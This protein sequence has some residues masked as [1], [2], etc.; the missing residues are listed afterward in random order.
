MPGSVPVSV[1]ILQSGFIQAA[2]STIDLTSRPGDLMHAG[3]DLPARRRW[4]RRRLAALLAALGLIAAQPVDAQQANEYLVKAAFIYNFAKFTTWPDSA[5]ADPHAPV[6][7]CIVGKH[8]FGDAFETV[9]G[10]SVGGRSVIVRYLTTF[11][12][13]DQCQVIYVAQSESSRLT[14]IVTAS[15]VSHALTVSEMDGFTDRC[16]MIRMVRDGADRIG[17]E[18]NPKAAEEAGL[19]FSSRLLNLAKRLVES[20][21]GAG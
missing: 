5:F 8:D 9:Q 3:G 17:F 2:V 13:K 16:G 6:T 14:R 20:C 4:R 19:K 7:L 10:K 18:I 21:G 12:N 15:R 11:R 1:F